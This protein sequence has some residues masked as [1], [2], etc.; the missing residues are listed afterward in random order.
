MAPD[1][2]LRRSGATFLIALTLVSLNTPVALPPPT[3]RSP[4]PRVKR[5][6]TR[7]ERLRIMQLNGTGM[8]RAVAD[9]VGVGR[10]TVLD[11]LKGEGVTLRPRGGGTTRSAG[12]NPPTEIGR[13]CRCWSLGSGRVW[14]PQPGGPTIACFNLP[15]PLPIQR[16]QDE[17]GNAA[18][19]SNHHQRE[20]RA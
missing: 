20:F 6:V 5:R 15:A 13:Y 3:D 2:R 7:R 17:F 1:P 9:K 11:V 19:F 14:M 10:T 16:S 8:S 18:R 4:K 12:P